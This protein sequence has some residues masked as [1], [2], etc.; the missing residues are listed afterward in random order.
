MDKWIKDFI[1]ERENLEKIADLTIPYDSVE[2]DELG[3]LRGKKTKVAE[4]KLQGDSSLWTE[5]VLER[6]Y[7]EHDWIEPEN[8]Y[9]KWRNEFE[10]GNALGVLVLE[11]NKKAIS[12]PLI[13]EDF[14]LKPLD[15]FY[16]PDEQK[17][18]PL[19]PHNIEKV[20]FSPD[21]T[22]ELAEPQRESGK[23]MQNVFAP[24]SGR[25]VHA[26]V[27]DEKMLDKIAFLEED[28]ADFHARIK[29]E[30][31]LFNA[32]QN[33]SYVKTAKK[34]INN[35][36][37]VKDEDLEK[38]AAAFIEP[39]PFE[40][41][42]I[43]IKTDKGLRTKT[44][45][46]Y[47]TYETLKN[48]FNLTKEAIDK[49]ISKVDDGKLIT[50]SK[51]KIA[52]IVEEPEVEQIRK[53]GAVEVET[54]DGNI[55]I[56]YAIPHIL[57]FEDG[58]L[59]PDGALVI[60]DNR[61]IL[62]FVNKVVGRPKEVQ[63]S[64]VDIMRTR[65]NEHPV[66]ND[67]VSFLWYD[68][69]IGDFTG[70]QPAKLIQYQQVHG[71]GEM[72][73]ILSPFGHK[74]NIII[75]KHLKSPDFSRDNKYQAIMLPEDSIWLKQGDE[76]RFSDNPAAIKEAMLKEYTPLKGKYFRSTDSFDF[77]QK[78]ASP[79]EVVL[80]LAS[81]GV[82]PGNIKKFIKESAMKKEAQIH[83]KLE[84]KK[85]AKNEIPEAVKN[86][87]TDTI[88]LASQIKNEETIDRILAINF[89]N[90]K[91]IAFFFKKLPKF[92]ETVDSLTALLLATRLGKVGVDEHVV[93]EAVQ[94]MQE[95][96]EKM[97]GYKFE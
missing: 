71:M 79:K 16:V 31:I 65:M 25:Y 59:M 13:V 97:E 21:M 66:R 72:F 87:K 28:I 48:E 53:S 73:T 5:Q 70:L 27:E 8:Y 41:Y 85:E 77:L 46:Y 55:S 60:D 44:A 20:F 58:Q 12:I 89:I 37:I 51:K 39:E 33:E 94:I 42:Q 82:E 22:D 56:V 6:M 61:E 54:A 74:Y 2:E 32:N 40:G 18:Y 17:L 47:E 49:K 26:S 14:H 78:E 9:V 30:D 76:V 3:V 88:K 67:L 83:V 62:N 81:L 7:E 75:A 35:P 50:V 11:K 92:K 96:V 69:R 57:R 68:K 84:K 93:R 36:N 23:I 86:L 43:T 80:E 95:L 45:S 4:Y 91:N 10:D 1:E 63:K 90:D 29:D 15:L 52:S 19:T 64:L 24:H 38:V 34:I